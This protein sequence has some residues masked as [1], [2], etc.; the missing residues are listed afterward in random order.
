M[1]ECGWI[2]ELLR[3][4]DEGADADV[5]VVEWWECEMDARRVGAVLCQWLL[6]CRCEGDALSVVVVVRV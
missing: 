6:R 2:L 3:A 5:A 4:N 1:L